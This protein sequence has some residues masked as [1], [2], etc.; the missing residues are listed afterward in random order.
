MRLHDADLVA[1]AAPPVPPPP[2]PPAPP[3]LPPPAAG[4]TTV[5]A[6]GDFSAAS[7][8]NSATGAFLRLVGVS[9][10]AAA[11]GAIIA[12]GGAWMIASYWAR[13]IGFFFSE[14]GL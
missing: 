6:H 7:E 4:V 11:I 3:T 5:H 12:L 14:I 2:P 13:P 10:L 9:L 8:G 1:V